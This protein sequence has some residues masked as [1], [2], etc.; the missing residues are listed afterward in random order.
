MT[1]L[2]I[3]GMRE[4]YK[5]LVRAHVV[6]HGWQNYWTSEE[7]VVR[8]LEWAAKHYM[9]RWRDFVRDTSKPEPYWEKRDYGFSI[10]LE[11]LVRFLILVDQK[12]L[13]EQYTDTLVGIL[14]EEV[15]DQ[16]I[17]EIPWLQ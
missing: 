7:E 5:W 10:G 4:A 15:S 8:R 17:S 16:P 6:R 12:G 13:A 14:V 3:Q 1:S 2:A 11:Y 9:S